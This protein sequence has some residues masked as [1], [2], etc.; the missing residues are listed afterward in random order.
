MKLQLIFILFF[1]VQILEYPIVQAEETPPITG[2]TIKD[3]MNEAL[4]YTQH[5]V[6]VCIHDFA[7]LD[8]GEYLVNAKTRGVR[9]RVVILRHK[10]NPSKGLLATE[11]IQ[12][13][14]DVRVINLP[15]NDHERNPHQDFIIL[16]DRILITGVYNWM[17]YLDRN[18]ND[19]VS[20]HYDKEK[21][22][23]YKN[24]FYKLFAEGNN[25]AMFISQKE[26]GETT[27]LP[28]SLPSSITRNDG[29]DVKKDSGTQP[30]EIESGD[31]HKNF[32]DVSFEELNKLFGEESSLSRSEKK[33][34]WEKY[35]GK[36]IRWNGMVVYKGIGRVDWNRVGISH[37]GN[38]KKA[39][40]IV[41][42]DW[43]MYQKVLSISEGNTI[44]YSGKLTSRPRLNSQ[45]R[46]QDGIIE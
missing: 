14:F 24:R 11:L 34:Q 41:L 37:Q 5:S 30:K 32:I 31:P 25:A 22:L 16:D 45:F 8:I 26:Q 42:F 20:F 33:A 28:V 9:A 36:Y 7:A 38:G 27:I 40:V 6:D 35:D 13:G 21:A 1:L 10:Y 44:T 17:A 39:D 15:D 46:V 23:V 18:I 2:N 43:K 3:K 19:C 4:Q 12:Q 29:Y